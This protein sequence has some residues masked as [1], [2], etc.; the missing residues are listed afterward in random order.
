M[1]WDM[2]QCHRFNLQNTKLVPC[3]EFLRMNLNPW[4]P[5]ASKQLKV[6]SW[7]HTSDGSVYSPDPR[8]THLSDANVFFK[9]HV[10]LLKIWVT[11]R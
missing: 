3:T 1:T 9:E 4:T 11:S 2:K 5:H 10:S 6:V 8:F 7:F